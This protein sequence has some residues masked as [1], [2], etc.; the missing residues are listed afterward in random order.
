MK[1][2]GLCILSVA[3]ILTS[4]VLFAGGLSWQPFSSGG[5]RVQMP[6]KPSCV[7]KV[8]TSHEF[9]IGENVCVV[10]TKQLNVSTEY[11]DL[12]GV[13]RT[14][15]GRN[16]IYKKS[17]KAFLADAGGRQVSFVSMSISGQ[18]GKELTYTTSKVTGA[19]RFVMVKDRL[20][21]V[22]ASVPL[23]TKS[24]ADMTKFLNSFSL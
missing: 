15:E 4:T 8:D 19:V 7:K 24:K 13:A 6:G 16:G 2:V 1:H 11:S 9:H 18:L 12:P 3:I 22:Q 17:A 5:Y 23:G 10:N 14:F 20:Y 21:V